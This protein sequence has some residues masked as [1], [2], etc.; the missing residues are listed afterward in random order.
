[1]NN[2]S[3][4]AIRNPVPPIAL[5]IFLLVVGLFGFKNLPVTQFPDI[6]VPVVI[7]TVT[8]VGAGPSEVSNQII[9]PIETE[10]TTVPGIDHV[11]SVAS[12]GL[13]TIT[14]SF[15]F[16]VDS[17]TALNNVDDA[18]TNVRSD[19]PD[20]IDEPSVTQLNF[21]GRTILTYAVTDPTQ[22]IEELSHFVD[23]TVAR[24]V[25]GA[26]SVGNVS[27]IGGADTAINID[28]DPNRL[29]AFGIT[30]SDV[31]TQLIARNVD[32]GAGSGAL[33]GQEVSIQ[34]LGGATTIDGLSSTPIT[35]ATGQV[36]RLDDVASVSVG[37][38]EISTFATVN[39]KPVVAF[40]IYRANGASDLTAA[41]NAKAE[42]EKLQ[43]LYPNAAF[44]LIDDATN[45]TEGNYESA[46]ETLYEG[47]VLA[48]IVVLLFLWN[49][50]AT[51]ITAV[52]LPLSIIPTFIVM[53]LL[54]FSLNTISLLGITLVTGILVDDAIVEIENIARH[55]DMG[56]SAYEAS[57]T[58][59]S[60][61]GTTVIA[62][63][64][65]IVA[66]FTPVSFMSG[67]AGQ[68]FKQFGLTVAVA[69][70]FSLLVARLIT[71]LMAAYF[72]RDGKM[73]LEEKDGWLMRRYM[74]L[75]GWTLRHRFI[76]LLVGAMIFA[77]SIYSAKLLPTEF[78]PR[79]DKGRSVITV[80]IPTGS[81]LANGRAVA[82]DVTNALLETPEVETVFV[83]ATSLTA[84]SV[85][86]NYGPKHERDRTSFEIID[87]LRTRL[88]SVPDAQI[89][90]AKDNGRRDIT[91]NVVGDTSEGA[92]QAAKAL[93]S[94]MRGLDGVISPSSDSAQTRPEIQITP[95]PALAAELGV[96]ISKIASTIQIAT[97]GGNGSNAAQYT[98]DD[99]QV[100]VLV[101]LDAQTRNDLSLLQNL[102]VSA[103]DG[104]LVPLDVIADVE[105]GSGP[106]SITRYD[107]Q[108]LTAVNGDLADGAVLGQ[109][110]QQIHGLPAAKNMPDGTSLLA[111]GDSE[112]QAEV[113]T[114][115]ALAMGTGLLLVYLVLVLLF[116]SFATPFAVLM[117]LPL[118]IGGAIFALYLAGAAI[119]LPVIIGFLMLM[120][121]VSKNAIMLV[122]FAAEGINNG[123]ERAEAIREAGHK[124]ARP[125]VMTTIAMTAGMVPSA[126][127]I[128]DGGEFRSPM[129]IAV[130]GGLL[131]S[132][133]L[134]LIFVPALFG[135]IDSLRTW[136]GSKLTSMTTRKTAR[137]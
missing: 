57:M 3:T 74:G 50:R 82:K 63:S 129:A 9:K 38:E 56:K 104:N 32:L 27:R 76:T 16:A 12:D 122:E 5:F 132:T 64:F 103:S 51:L 107:G 73:P 118:A 106:A 42:I 20:A 66:V 77:G 78:I 34:S 47:A 1:M 52:A 110:M 88:K 55:L 75:L 84:A 40:G 125:I 133:L 62:I 95:R 93:V 4:W 81:T 53:D 137:S 101:R 2:I 97:L 37:T 127:A 29:L 24:A 117:S 80:E 8:Q 69:V 134:S 112:R 102:R 113:F 92:A 35:L 90:V 136:I 28:L 87:E 67:I 105:V 49:W 13:A 116:S 6:D 128:G 48:V 120:G 30:A 18:V 10:L 85:S 31:N 100:P 83:N 14:V 123:L 65:T 54:G 72:L 23:D 126:L 17:L 121:I 39:N 131:L 68:Y 99:R 111:G 89:F 46:L 70:L 43:D 71:P 15:E 114:G 124:R 61:I 91:V 36:I 96:N 135:S 7:V 109:T 11:T 19:L 119:G 45:Y 25:S 21:T 79:T 44:S 115:F 22:T 108:Y 33:A 60:E 86:V 26:G 94:E 58:A 41:E 130:I 59:A 98:L